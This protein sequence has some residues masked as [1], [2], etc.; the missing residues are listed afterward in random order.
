VTGS[1][2][3][4]WALHKCATISLVSSPAF[5]K[6]AAFVHDEAHLSSEDIA[7]ATGAAP[8]TARAWVALKRIP[9]GTRAQRIAELSS[10]S[11]RLLRVMDPEYIPVWMNKPV[12]ALDD[13]KP[14]ELISGG[15]Y[16]RV[17]RIVSALEEPVAT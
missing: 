14:I 17:A 13:R 6:E 7:A 15:E 12:P 11:E 2:D 8:S 10:I 4:L 3:A 1:T 5:A 16:L 9:S